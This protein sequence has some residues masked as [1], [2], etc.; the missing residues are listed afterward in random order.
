MTESADGRL[1]IVRPRGMRVRIPLRA[2][3]PQVGWPYPKMSV[4]PAT[5]FLCTPRLRWTGLCGC[6]SRPESTAWCAQ[7]DRRIDRRRSRSGVRLSGRGSRYSWAWLSALRWRVA[8]DGAAL[9]RV[10]P[11]PIPGRWLYLTGGAPGERRMEAPHRLRG[12]LARAGRGMR[13]GYAGDTARQRGPDGPASRLH[14]GE[15]L[16]PPLA[17]PLPATWAGK[18]A[19]TEDRACRVGRGLIVERYPGG[20]RSGAAAFGRVPR[21]QPGAAD[22]C[23]AASDGTSIRAICSPTSQRTSCGCAVRRSD[24]LGVEW[25]Y[26]RPNTISVAKRD[27]VARLDESSGLSTDVHASADDGGSGTCAL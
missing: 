20:V 13:T 11:G 21:A 6:R 12:R 26:S 3:F 27:A 24:R 2:P 25:R 15:G 18:E 10:S 22:S 1:K 16:L 8:L 23:R 17:L 14:R 19:P 5:L 9:T 7:G 4:A